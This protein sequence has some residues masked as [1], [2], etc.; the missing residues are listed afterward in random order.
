M[1]TAK[2]TGSRGIVPLDSVRVRVPGWVLRL[3]IPGLPYSE[4][5]FASIGRRIPTE[6]E[7]AVL[8]DVHGVAYLISRQDYRR[9]VASEGGGTAYQDISVTGVPVADVDRARTGDRVTLRTLGTALRR[10]PY[11]APSGR[12][13]VRLL[14]TPSSDNAQHI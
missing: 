8:P 12:Y 7:D 9:V 6:T 14:W 3:E 13:M 2:F 4:P 1:S 10:R 5:A 11:P